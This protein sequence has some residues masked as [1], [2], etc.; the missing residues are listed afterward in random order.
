MAISGGAQPQQGV[1]AGQQGT[2]GSLRGNQA[3]GPVSEWP[4]LVL[5]V[6]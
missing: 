1:S 5:P 2:G 6:F 3:W 4:L